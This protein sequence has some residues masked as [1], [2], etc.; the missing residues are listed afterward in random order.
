MGGEVEDLKNKKKLLV[1]CLAVTLAVGGCCGAAEHGE[2]GEIRGAK[3]TTSLPA[4]LAVPGGMD[5]IVSSHGNSR[6]PGGIGRGGPGNKKE[7]ALVIRGSTGFQFRLAAAVF[8]PGVV[9]V[10][11]CVATGAMACDT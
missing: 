11:L 8:R 9:S 4:R 7:R 5:D 3:A 2:Y 10:C 6:I 1:I